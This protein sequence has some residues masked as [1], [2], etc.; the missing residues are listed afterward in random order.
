MYFSP[1]AALTAK[2]RPKTCILLLLFIK[3][4]LRASKIFNISPV[5]TGT[6]RCVSCDVATIRVGQKFSLIIRLVSSS[7]CRRSSPP[8][9]AQSTT[10]LWRCWCGNLYQ[11]WMSCSRFQISHRCRD[12]FSS[13]FPD[14]FYQDQLLPSSNVMFWLCLELLFTARLEL[15]VP[16]EACVLSLVNNKAA[17]KRAPSV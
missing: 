6:K 1:S 14:Y 4:D 5:S 12:S 16:S 9:L 7:L 8:T 17:L 11:G 10:R 15:E 13:C 2:E 3:L